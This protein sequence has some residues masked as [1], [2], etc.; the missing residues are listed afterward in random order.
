MSHK[1][2][3]EVA[4]YRAS[5]SQTFNVTQCYAHAIL[6]SRNAIGSCQ[7]LHGSEIDD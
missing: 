6:M 3:L 5:L 7:C 4:K 1:D 2:A